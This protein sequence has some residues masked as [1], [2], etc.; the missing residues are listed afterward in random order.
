[1]K[2]TKVLLDFLL[3]VRNDPVIDS[4]HISIYLTIY[5][6]WL[7]SGCEDRFRIFTTEI[8]S[9]AKISSTAT[10]YKK[11]RELKECNYIRYYPD[12]CAIRGTYVGVEV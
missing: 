7:I 11:I 6:K 10:Y 1:M 12:N 9:E 5:Y 8:M 2:E 4:K 3:R